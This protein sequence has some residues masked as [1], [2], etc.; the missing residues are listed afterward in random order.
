MRLQASRHCLQA[1]ARWIYL[2]WHFSFHIYRN[3][4]FSIYRGDIIATKSCV[5]FGTLP[6]PWGISKTTEFWNNKSLESA[7][8]LL[9]T[10]SIV[11]GCRSVS[12]A[13]RFV[14]TLSVPFAFCCFIFSFC[15]FFLHNTQPQPQH[16][17]AYEYGRIQQAGRGRRMEGEGKGK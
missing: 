13:L 4:P 5:S 8:W 17:C 7:H 6:F 1:F 11:S 2:P 15:S 9:S 14:H 3:S 12:C 10:S 16:M